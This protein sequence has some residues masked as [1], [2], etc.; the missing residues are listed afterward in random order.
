VVLNIVPSAVK[1]VSDCLWKW[2]L[3]QV[4]DFSSDLEKEGTVPKKHQ[5]RYPKTCLKTPLNIKLA[6][7][8]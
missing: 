1:W 8:T 7:Y 3:V 2:S 5:H 6:S 4:L